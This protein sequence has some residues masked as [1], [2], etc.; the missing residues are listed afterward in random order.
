MMIGGKHNINYFTQ[1]LLI[2]KGDTLMNKVIAVLLIL[3]CAASMAFSQTLTLDPMGVAPRQAEEDSTD[4]F[5]HGYSALLNVG[6]ETRMYL[7]ASSDTTLAPLT[8]TVTSAPD[9]SEADVA[10]ETEL[11]SANY[12]VSFVPDLEGTYV[13]EV[14]DGA[15]TA[16]LTINAGLY[17]GIA[18]GGCNFCHADKVTEWEGTGHA[19]MLERGLDGALSA[20]YGASCIGCHTVGNDP[21]ANNNGFDDR[22]FVFPDTLYPGVYAA[23]LAA[24]PDAMKLAN[25][26]CESCHGPGSAHMGDVTDSK[27]VAS[28]D[29]QACAIC[30]DE[31]SHHAFP[32]QWRMSVHGNPTTLSRGTRSSCAE[33]HSGSAFNAWVEN[34]KDLTGVTIPTPEPISCAVCHDPHSAENEHQMRMVDDVVLGNGLVV[35]DGGNGKLCMNC[36]KGRRDTPT[37][38]GTSGPHHGPQTDVLVGANA[39]T[40]GKILPSSPHLQATE[41]ACADCHMAGGIWDDARDEVASSGGHSFSMVNSYGEDHV[42]VCEPCHGDVG[43]SFNEKKYFFQGN[44]D[45]DGDGTEEGIQEEIHGLL[46][47]LGM[48]LPPL[49]SPEVDL[50]DEYTET[51]RKAAFNYLFIEEDRSSGVHNPAFAVALLKVSIQAV[52][53]SSLDGEIVAIEDVPNDQGKQVHLV[54]DSMADDGIA[55]DPIEKYLVKRF[56][57]DSTAWTT[58]SEVTAT[59]SARYAL[60]VPTLFD[61]TI[62]AGQHLTTFVVSAISKGGMVYTSSEASGYSLDNLAPMAPQNLG[63]AVAGNGIAL[64][65]DKATDKDFNYFALY[66]GTSADF[67]PGEANLVAKMSENTYVDDA[68]S[69]DGTYYYKLSAIDHSG[70]QSKFADVSVV[71][72][73]L[74]EIADSKIPDTY[75]LNQNYPNPFNPSTTIRFGLPEAQD[76]RIVVYNLLG[77]PV[78]TLVNGNFAAGYHNVTWDGRNEHGQV[79]S[80]SMY[81]Y[82]LESGAAT[83]TNKMLLIK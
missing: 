34:G 30:H 39:Y 40:F 17:E 56:D 3:V 46:E 72:D 27:M 7:R 24:Y 79:V 81:I 73:A 53:N 1:H 70:N 28:L 32:A 69:S 16:T 31:G 47:E 60:V 67:V 78:R 66:R 38:T 54:W 22:T 43:T 10:D 44:A 14:T 15:N 26:Q 12:V 64:T 19:S 75:I 2:N 83:I 21:F 37:Y 48:L 6:V 41:N 18:D 5:E 62:A 8:W 13:V 11:D 4:I 55:D 25:I 33:C 36:H 49:G 59:G 63:G 23:T 57:D 82:R 20:G 35:S 50:P 42:E 61:S 52:M 45:H 68:L 80:A 58:V 77:K 9:G 76:V 74:G 71:V 51:E 29:A 65:W